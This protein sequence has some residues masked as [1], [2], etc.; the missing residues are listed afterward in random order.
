MGDQCLK[1]EHRFDVAFD[2]KAP[3][4]IAAGCDARAASPCSKSMDDEEITGLSILG[5]P[6][7]GYFVEIGGHD[8]RVFSNTLLM[9]LCLGWR[10]AMIEANPEN[11]E[12][13]VKNRPNT[14]N[15]GKA[16]CSASR[17]GKMK[18][19]GRGAVGGAAGLQN[20]RFEKD[21]ARHRQDHSLEVPCAP[22]DRL[23]DEAGAPRHVDFWTLE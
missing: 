18:F 17:S 16:A 13:L 4:I 1:C 14:S 20:D 5:W 10:G 23:L 15:I 11:Y 22:F 3:H 7:G 21:V 12:Q 6:A 8:G 19:V 9:E 2:R